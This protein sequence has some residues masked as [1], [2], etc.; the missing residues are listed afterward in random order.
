MNNGVHEGLSNR[1]LRVV[2][3]RHHND[4]RRFQVIAPLDKELWGSPDIYVLPGQVISEVGEEFFVR[5][6]SPVAVH[7]C[8]R[9]ELQACRGGLVQQLNARRGGGVRW[10]L[11]RRQL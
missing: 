7:G 8:N 9:H 10:I 11:G 6:H 2:N 5:D 1:A 3:D 4:V